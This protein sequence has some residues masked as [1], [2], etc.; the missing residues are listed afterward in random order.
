MVLTASCQ[1]TEKSIGLK[2]K[3]TIGVGSGGLFLPFIIARENGF[4]QEEG[5]DATIRI[6]PSGKKAME[7]MFAGEVDI[8]TVADTPI[9]MT[10]FMRDD[11]SV[12]ATFAHSYD[13]CKVIG[14]KDRG[15]SKPEDLKG[16]KIG[17]A[18]GTA[19]LFF[20]HIYLAEHGVDPSAVKMVDFAPA[21]VLGVLEEGKV[22][23]I[24]IYE[25]YASMA[26][27]ALPG[28]AVRMPVSD[29][30]KQTFTLAVMK[31][32]T[33]EHSGL[34]KKFLKAVDRAITFVSQNRNE[35]IAVMTKNLTLQEKSLV[36][37]QDD[38]VF[39]L[40]LGHS[41]LT[42]LEDQARWA[43]KNG[44]SNKTKIPNYLDYLYLD[45]MKAV[46]PKSVTIIKIG[47]NP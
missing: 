10:S 28:T 1:K 20:A 42:M 22:D 7:A 15:V 18:S 14:R 44:Y 46:K 30:Y 24:V 27:K 45:A 43:M 31:S 16:K 6:Y 21:D 35:S 33:K 2:E 29:L 47:S 3:V 32:Y 19:A 4:F 8:A 12:F 17:I 25:P 11:F 39:E 41:L 5:L 38:L 9:V 36:S 40:S 34:L 26:M 13:D 23:A 37:F